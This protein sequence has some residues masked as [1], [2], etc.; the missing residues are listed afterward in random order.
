ML[1]EENPSEIFL[2]PIRIFMAALQEF[3]ETEPRCIKQ[4]EMFLILDEIGKRYHTT[5]LTAYNVRGMM[6]IKKER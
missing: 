6:K 5:V 4:P 3:Y 2:F 1:P